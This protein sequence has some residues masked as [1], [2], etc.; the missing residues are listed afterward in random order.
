MCVRNRPENLSDSLKFSEKVNPVAFLRTTASLSVLLAFLDL[1]TPA[2][3]MKK[4]WV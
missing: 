1:N 4:L 3:W 2:E